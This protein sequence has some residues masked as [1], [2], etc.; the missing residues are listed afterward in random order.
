MQHSISKVRSFYEELTGLAQVIA[1]QE[2]V[3]AIRCELSDRRAEFR[4][5]RRELRQLQV[6]VQDI[7]RQIDGIPRTHADFITLVTKE[8]SLLKTEQEIAGSCRTLEEKERESFDKLFEA[9]S[10][11]HS[12]ERAYT[13][14]TKYWSVIGS[15]SGTLIGIIGSTLVSRR[16][17]KEL[18][19]HVTGSVAAVLDQQ[20]E[21]EAGVTAIQ[22][23]NLEKEMKMQGGRLR[24][25]NESIQKRETG[26][27]ALFEDSI[28]AQGKC[29]ESLTESVGK[30]EKMLGSDED[31]GEDD[32][33]LITVEEIVWGGC[34]ALAGLV[35][36]WSLSYR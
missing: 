35:A 15:V 24:S 3:Q 29:L 9:V 28:V 17:N 7:R 33:G 26:E 34:M 36:F 16:R 10:E 2:T 19:N 14:R 30:I 32:E 31:G 21:K 4:E 20:K 1:S 27:S 13:D 6:Q 11:S 12:Q 22:I 23:E 5:R 8:H 25:L 18:K